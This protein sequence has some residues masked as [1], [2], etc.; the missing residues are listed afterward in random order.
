MI[1][2]TLENNFPRISIVTP[3]FNQVRYI[4]R[5]IRSTLNQGYP[6]LE[7]LVIDGGSTDGTVDV[8]K[9]YESKLSYCIS[10]RDNGQ[11]SAINKGLKRATGDWVGW[12]NSDDIYFEGTLA[13]V[14]EATRKNPDV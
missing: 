13:S 1:S 5:T 7:Y 12:Q 10:E 14:A 3:S 9:R 2:Q 8:I 11:I 4:E 6:N